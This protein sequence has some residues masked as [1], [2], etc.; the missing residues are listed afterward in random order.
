MRHFAAAGGCSMNDRLAWQ[1]YRRTAR[2]DAPCAGGHPDAAAAFRRQPGLVADLHVL[3]RTT[4]TTAWPSL[5]LDAWLPT[6]ETLH[7]Y[8]QIVGKVQLALTPM[9]NHFWNVALRVTARGLSTSALR[10]AGRT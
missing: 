2:R 10:Y 4:M 5:P 7:R 8:T 9:V 3:E 1:R 6:R